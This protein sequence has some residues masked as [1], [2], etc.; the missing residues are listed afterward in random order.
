MISYL[1][2]TL[3]W[4]LGCLALSPPNPRAVKY[5]KMLAGMFFGTLIPLIYFFIQ[6]KVHRVAGGNGQHA[7][8]S[9]KAD[10]ISLHNIR[11]FRMVFNPLRRGLRRR[12]SSGLRGP[13]A[14]RAQ[15]EGTE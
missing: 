7:I 2:A 3:P 15:H 4:T 14:G 1:V 11:F 12:N 9:S 10:C 13:R 8:L 6:H 5:R